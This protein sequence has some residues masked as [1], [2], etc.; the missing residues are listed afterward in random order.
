M[1]AEKIRQNKVRN[2]TKVIPIFKIDGKIWTQN[3]AKKIRRNKENQ[4][5]IHFTKIFRIYR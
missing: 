3:S 2:Y 1:L 5:I 4:Q